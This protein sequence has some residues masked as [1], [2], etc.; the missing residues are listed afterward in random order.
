MTKK[1]STKW[2]Q[3]LAPD[4]ARTVSVLLFSLFT[5]LLHAQE[6]AADPTIKMREQLRAVMLQ[7]RTSQS[8]VANAQAEKIAAEQKFTAL[9][10]E[11]KS[12]RAENTKLTKQVLTEKAASEET[13]AGLN[14]KIAQRDK[15][16]LEYEEAL[17]KWQT[18]Y[19]K[20]AAIARSK[21]DQRAALASEVVVHKRDIADLQ[22]KNI[23]LFNTS[24]E[25]L[26]RYEGYALG[27][28]LAARE[29]F[30]GTTRVKVENLVQGYKDKVL[31]NRLAAPV[32][33]P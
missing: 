5:S 22:R 16:A 8:E 6:E 3:R 32:A 11:T 2:L 7:L 4:R 13:I 20:A 28:A 30:I 24:M 29:P 33:K 12:L 15:K 9:E 31:D 23:A 18:G 17:G 26:D 25:I 21:E 10:G 14:Q 19:E 1:S 27:K